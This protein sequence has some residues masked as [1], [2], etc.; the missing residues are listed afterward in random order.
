MEDDPAEWKLHLA[1]P[2]AAA[3]AAKLGSSAPKALRLAGCP[4]LAPPPAAPPFWRAVEHGDLAAVTTLL[5]AGEPID[6]LGGPY[7]STALGW[8]AFSGNL[9]LAKLC[10]A[11]GAKPNTKARK[12]STPLH[13]ATWNGDHEAL[14]AALLE[15]SADPKMT[16]AAGLTP[17]AQAKWFDALESKSSAETR[18]GLAA[19]REQW[20][21]PA[22]GRANVIAR[23][24]AVT[25]AE[26]EGAETDAPM[27]S[28]GEAKEAEAAEPKKEADPEDEQMEDEV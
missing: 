10:L 7:G 9:E 20:G 24:A 19:W 15:A 8:A 21:L 28:G 11:R 18:Y 17:L 13:M 25:G 27:A 3:A 6:Q 16:N 1:E 12:G 14:V 23:L 4:M 5:E 2:D 26:G 22:A